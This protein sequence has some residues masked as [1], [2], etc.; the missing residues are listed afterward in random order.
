MDHQPVAAGL[1]AAPDHAGPPMGMDGGEAPSAGMRRK[2]QI[3]GATPDSL[4]ET[5]PT[6]DTFTQDTPTYTQAP[7]RPVRP[8][9]VVSQSS[10][11][12]TGGTGSPVRNQASFFR[13]K[14][15]VIQDIQ[16]RIQAVMDSVENVISDLREKASDVAR[17]QLDYADEVL[18]KIKGNLGGLLQKAKPNS[19]EQM[20]LKSADHAL[21]RLVKVVEDIERKLTPDEDD[22][23]EYVDDIEREVEGEVGNEAE[24]QVDNVR[25]I[26][27]NATVEA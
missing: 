17:T 18:H 9:P 22:Y 13:R 19:F 25:Q 3:F 15:D 26:A 23:S 16:A 27:A 24:A 20:I 2:R 12:R 14:R 4:A 6:P 8:R 11:G 10:Y 1:D 21:Q 5:R 7:R